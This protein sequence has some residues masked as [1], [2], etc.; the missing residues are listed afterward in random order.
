MPPHAFE[1]A[2]DGARLHVVADASPG[3]P[4]VTCLHALGAD[5]RMWEPQAAALRGRY[6]LLRV[7]LRGHGGSS[8]SANGYALARLG[9]DVVCLWDDLGIARSHVVGVSLGGMIALGLG[10][11]HP[12]RTAGIVAAGCRADAPEPFRRMWSDRRALLARDGLPALAEATLAAWFPGAVDAEVRDL[13]RA[14]IEGI[15]PAAY[16]AISSELQSLALKPR[17]AA[18]RRPVHLIC[19]AAD[20]AHPAA[21]REMAQL[22]PDAALTVLEGCGHLSNLEDAEAFTAAATAFLRGFDA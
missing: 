5:A 1:L 11:D 15:A 22:I 4:W 13:A 3:R 19:G 12:G 7:D 18:M 6:N 21:M 9:A 20:G 17:L 2:V 16:V 8:A 10:L 14:M